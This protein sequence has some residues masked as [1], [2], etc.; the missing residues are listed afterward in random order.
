MFLA[1]DCDTQAVKAANWLQPGVTVAANI[2]EATNSI[3]L[4]ALAFNV[5]VLGLKR[6]PLATGRS[7]VTERPERSSTSAG[8]DPGHYSISKRSHCAHSYT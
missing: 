7:H 1:E 2:L 3:K 6:T 4:P 5:L 8:H